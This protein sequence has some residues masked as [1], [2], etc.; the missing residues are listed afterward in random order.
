MADID[1]LTGKSVFRNFIRYAGLNT[2][3]NVAAAICVFLDYWFISTAIGTDGLTALSLSIPIYSFVYGIGVML[4]IGGGAKYAGLR[5]DGKDDDANRIFTMTFR[6]GCFI[7]IPFIFTGVFLTRPVGILLG[8]EGHILPMSVSYLRILLIF[9]P[10]LIMYGIFESF[11]RNDNAPKAAMISAVIYSF[12]NVIWDYIFILLF[13]WGMFGAALATTCAG[14]MGLGYLLIIWSKKKVQYKLIKTK[15]KISEMIS[16]CKIGGPS[17]I[18][19]FIYGFVL[20][21]FNLTFLRLSGNTGV[22]AFGV[23]SGF[24][25]VVLYFFLGI[26][27]GIQPLGSFYYGR[28]EGENLAKI[29][30]Y[31]FT[32]CISFGIIV[33]LIVFMFTEDVTA[34]LNSEEDIVLAELANN[35]IRIYFSAFLVVGISM[36]IIDYLSVT[37]APGT[38]LILSL[39]QN[40]LLVIPIILVLSRIFGINGAWAAYPVS[41]VILVFVCIA[42]LINAKKK[43]RIHFS[44]KESIS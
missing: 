42:A 29:L 41:E 26:A 19:E 44:K 34:L 15:S 6:M 20:I 22:A 30:K 40:G 28:R 3:G 37:N 18:S 1:N 10:A 13:G 24:E 32:T 2:V 4:G 39:L 16:V 36:V 12:M 9:S 38:A 25:F 21:A 7:T 27:Q 11:S 35:G 31:S 14:T 33:V 23:V 43:Q 17:F 5:A 8:G